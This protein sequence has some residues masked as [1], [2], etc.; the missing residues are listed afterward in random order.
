MGGPRYL[1]VEATPKATIRERR[2]LTRARIVAE[3][4]KKF[5]VEAVVKAIEHLAGPSAMAGK[6]TSGVKLSR[7]QKAIGGI[8]K[9]AHDVE[10]YIIHAFGSVFAVCCTA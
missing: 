3:A 5:A 2:C 4:G 7:I 6:A 1:G 8:E 10:G 9:V